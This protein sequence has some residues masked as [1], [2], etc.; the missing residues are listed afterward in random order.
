MIV[1]MNLVTEIQ[2]IIRRDFEPA[3][4]GLINPQ[5]STGS[6]ADPIYLLDGEFV[7]LNASYQV[8]RE[9]RGATA[10][11]ITGGDPAVNPA[12]NDAASKMPSFA[13]WAERGRYDV[14]A[15]RKVPVLFLF[16]YEADFGSD[17]LVSTDTFAVGDILY[18][19]W[20]A[21]GANANRRRGLTKVSGAIVGGSQPAVVHA[22][23]TRTFSSGL[24]RMRA[25]IVAP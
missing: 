24:Y 23:V 5:N 2:P 22:Y 13:V 12:G 25:L 4:A 1:N 14:Q 8:S 11:T 17:V 19:N 7:M 18:V 9:G 16:G 3:T 20:L 10:A 6:A 15:V 21:N